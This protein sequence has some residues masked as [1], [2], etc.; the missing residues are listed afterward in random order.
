M[1]K[2]LMILGIAGLMLALVTGCEGDMWGLMPPQV[3]TEDFETEWLTGA[4]VPEDP[5]CPGRTVD[6]AVEF[7]DERANGGKY[8]AMFFLDGRQDDGTIWLTRSFSAPS[9]GAR[10][11]VTIAFD[12]WSESASDNTIAKVAFYGGGQRPQQEADFDTSQAANQA[13]GWRRY[14]SVQ[15]VTA[16]ADSRFW[17]AFGI[18]A[19]WE[20]EMT[21][22][23]DNLTVTFRSQ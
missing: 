23:I 6:W 13:A 1:N 15:Q 9:P 22:F 3:L 18:S 16:G 5:N 17:I 20:T 8:S 14:T 12:L 19:V 10:Y 21:Y 4:D 7:S 2:N 11:E